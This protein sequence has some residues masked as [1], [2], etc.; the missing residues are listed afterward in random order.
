[1]LHLGMLHRRLLVLVPS[2]L[3]IR[4][5]TRHPCLC[6]APYWRIRQSSQRLRAHLLLS[7]APS[8]LLEMF[9]LQRWDLC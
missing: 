8:V 9:L 6:L 1:M 7:L 4:F 2:H 3:Q 5:L